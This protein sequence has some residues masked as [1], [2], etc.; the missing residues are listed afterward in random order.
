MFFRVAALLACLPYVSGDALVNSL[1]DEIFEEESGVF[2]GIENDDEKDRGWRWRNT[3]SLTI[4]VELAVTPWTWGLL[5]RAWT[6]SDFTEWQ[7]YFRFLFL[8]IRMHTDIG[9]VSSESR[10]QRWFALSE[11]EAWERSK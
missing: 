11:D 5:P 9:N 10:F 7:G 2:D 4:A 1:Y 3:R 8:A 6:Y